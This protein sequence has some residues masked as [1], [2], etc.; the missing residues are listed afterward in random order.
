MCP[1]S[2]QGLGQLPG[3]TE[4]GGVEALGEPG[5]DRLQEIASLSALALPMPQASDARRCAELQRPGL[6]VSRHVDGPPK[7]RLG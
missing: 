6:L 5:V 1:S 7:T 2:G 3:L 4:V